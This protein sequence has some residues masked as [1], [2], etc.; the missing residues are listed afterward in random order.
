MVLT[1]LRPQHYDCNITKPCALQGVAGVYPG[2]SGEDDDDEERRVLRG[3]SWLPQWEVTGADG[4]CWRWGELVAELVG[5]G[6]SILLYDLLE[7]TF[8]DGG[9]PPFLP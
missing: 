5:S 9:H 4:D 6:H 8:L 1:A 3:W 2:V 7:A